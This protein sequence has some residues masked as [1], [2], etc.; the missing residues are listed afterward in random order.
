[1]S[2]PAAVMV[3]IASLTM[4]SGNPR[5]NDPATAGVADSIRRFGFGAPILARRANGEVIAGHT[6]LKAAIQLGL[7][8]VPVRYMDLSET[9]AHAYALADNK[10][11]EAADWEMDALATALR[12]LQDADVKIGDLGWDAGELD[13]ILDQFPEPDP[14]PDPEPKDPMDG[15]KEGWQVLVNCKSE[16][17][18]AELLMELKNR[19]LWVRAILT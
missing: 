9:E 12:D 13:A 4:W 8:E 3:S 5:I 7:A 1:M 11:G 19:G 16:Q 10:L 14:Q 6:R 17:Q 15:Y 2:E 18:Q